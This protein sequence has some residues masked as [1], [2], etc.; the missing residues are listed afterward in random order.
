MNFYNYNSVA[1]SGIFSG[2]SLKFCPLQSI[3]E[4]WQTQSFG[5]SL[6]GPQNSSGKSVRLELH[7]NFE[8]GMLPIFFLANLFGV[9]HVIPLRS[10]G[11]VFKNSFSHFSLQ[12]H[13]NGF[14]PKWT[15]WIDASGSN[16]PFGKVFIWLSNNELIYVK[17]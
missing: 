7:L 15:V 4:P 8:F 9:L 5:H 12:S 11:F 6:T 3:T 14:L 16:S 2:I 17:F 10:T 1:Y 13:T